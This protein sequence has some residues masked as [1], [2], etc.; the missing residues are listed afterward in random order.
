MV[1]LYIIDKAGCAGWN[2]PGAP[3]PVFYSI[4]ALIVRP[5]SA[6]TASFAGTPS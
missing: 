1:R 4:S 3:F 2:S 6:Y 5:I